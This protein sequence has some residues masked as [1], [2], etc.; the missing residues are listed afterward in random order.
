M[1]YVYNLQIYNYIYIYPNI[2]Q[3]KSQNSAIPSLDPNLLG[4]VGSRGPE[5]EEKPPWKSAE[6]SVSLG[7]ELFFR[8]PTK[9]HRE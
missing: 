3:F 5:A 2:F 7:S 8:M 1:M 4:A 6:R 9:K